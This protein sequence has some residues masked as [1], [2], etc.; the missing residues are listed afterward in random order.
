M[1]TCVIT[2]TR[3]GEAHC[4][5]TDALDLGSLGHL[6]ITRA[7]RI[8]FNPDQQAWEVHSNSHELLF[9]NRSR[10]VCLAWEHQYFNR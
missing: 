8:E 9:T 4:L 3:T 1:N 7:A 6:E 2:F 10:S 5:H